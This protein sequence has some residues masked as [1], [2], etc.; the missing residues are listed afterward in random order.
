MKRLNNRGVS[1]IEILIAVV[2][3]VMCITPIINQLA[4][5]IRIGQRADDQQA[6]TDY[7]KS[8]AESVKQMDLTD[9]TD[10]SDTATQ[11]KIASE[12]GLDTTQTYA[13]TCS[14]YSVDKD[15]N[16]GGVIPEGST[17]GTGGYL[18]VTAMYQTLNLYNKTVTDDAQQALVRQYTI[19]GTADIDYR[20][21][22]VEIVLDTEPYAIASLN[23]SDYV[24]PNAVN[25]GNLS[26]L[27]SKTTAVITNVSSYDSVASASYYNMVLAALQASDSEADQ[28]LAIQIKE[29]NRTISEMATKQ[30]VLTV[31]PIGSGADTTYRVTCDIIYN[32]QEIV[33]EY[34]LTA[35]E[36][37]LD[38][39]AYTQ[40]FDDMPDVY[41]MYNQFLY[42]SSYGTDTIQI[43]NNTT[44]EAKIYVV[45]TAESDAGV[46]DIVD[47][48][49]SGDSLLPAAN[50]SRDVVDT[51]GN[52][53]YFTHFAI[54][55]NLTTYP[56]SIYT[57]ID[58]TDNVSS[59]VA[60]WSGSTASVTSYDTKCK[61]SVNSTSPESVV[62]SLSEDER[63]SE[64]GRAYNI[65]I[66][67]TRLNS[68][69][70]ETNYVTTFD[71][72]KG[73]Y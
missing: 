39:V 66:T 48:S 70:T 18:S 37:T 35:S 21:Y 49:A 44:N 1:L 57:N 42:L 27:N 38:Y 33:T 12:F 32:N 54:K 40:E 41:L 46:S 14:F 59:S 7:G 26:S 23:S 16:K 22:D 68:D 50:N 9:L 4:S 60:T 20:T 73:D 71:T 67:L 53:V 25:L 24:D 3:F 15:G 19:T 6:A 8:V 36:T 11:E 17:V 31:D 47:L 65:L 29:G 43:V 64:S 30:I 45:R 28:N 61:M 13:V 62:L 72:S 56:V 10:I 34:G 2:I 58:T 55:N 52:Y 63:Y 51:S 5:G 69:G